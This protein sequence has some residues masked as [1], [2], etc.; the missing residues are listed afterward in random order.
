MGL[1]GKDNRVNPSF[2]LLTN[3]DNDESKLEVSSQVHSIVV[4]HAV[5]SI[6]AAE[7]YIYD[8]DSAS[9]EFAASDDANLQP[10][11]ELTIKLGYNEDD[12]HVFTGVIVLQGIRHK[13]KGAPLLYLELKHPAIAM[14]HARKNAI[15]T[16]TNDLDVISDF[17]I[18][19]SI[20]PN[21]LDPADESTVTHKELVKIN[22]SDWDFTV[23]RAE[24]NGKFVYTNLDGGVDVKAP[25]VSQAESVR[26]VVYGQDV[27]E[28]EA[29][30]DARHQYAKVEAYSWD[31]V[32]QAEV[33]GDAENISTITEHGTEVKSKD[34]AA[35]F[36]DGTY[37]LYHA[38]R[39]DGENEMKAWAEAKLQKSRLSKVRG[40]V[41]IAGSAEI[42]PG[43]TIELDGFSKVFNGF[44]FVSSVQH[45][46][47]AGRWVTDLEIG[48][49]PDWFIKSYDVNDLPVSGLLSPARG[50]QVGT[51][52][53]VEEDPDKLFRVQVILPILKDTTAVIW[54][55]MASPDAGP[56]R[57]FFFR[58]QIDDEVIVGFVNEDP[59]DPVILGLL[60][61]NDALKPPFEHDKN[62]KQGIK[63]K[64]GLILEFDDEHKYI[65]LL[66]PN[67]N[68][69]KISDDGDEILIADANGNTFTMNADGI[70]IESAKDLILK[71]TGDVDVS[72]V[73]ISNS[74]NGQ[75]TAD[76]TGGIELTS[77][78][79]AK[80]QG[81]VVQIN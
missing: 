37:T 50:L 4:H 62:Q 38:G 66:T 73:N 81:S 46:M 16:D 34:L 60:H 67:G 29:E 22:V 74:A 53:K 49:T 56:E 59:R 8:G 63:T 45:Q 55:R 11:K 64:E 23:T 70:T 25:K 26:A 6:S 27:Y 12:E 9:Q 78:G 42:L 61:N 52:N 40:R 39:V 1:F 48:I 21:S 24:A 31:S 15:Y 19:K 75:F 58:P 28:I 57:G 51:V 65:D 30:V 44:A 76:G 2:K 32:K 69:V 43:N 72:G 68:N 14:A 20:K 35:I 5:N 33:P 80:L 54:A 47:Q 3:K 77:S 10:G 41:R 36:G 79:V 71:A 13:Q 17:L 7:I 18:P